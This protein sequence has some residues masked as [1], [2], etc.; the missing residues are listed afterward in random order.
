MKTIKITEET[1]NK[2]MLIKAAFNLRTIDSTIQMLIDDHEF[3]NQILRL[4]KDGNK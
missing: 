3:T 4:T 2:I 1:H